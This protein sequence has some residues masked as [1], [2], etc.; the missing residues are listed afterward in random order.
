MSLYLTEHSQKYYIRYS[1]LVAT[2]IHLFFDVKLWY[3]SPNY[4]LFTEF[5]KIKKQ[6]SSNQ[7]DRI[8]IHVN[9]YIKTC[10][11]K[12]DQVY[13]ECFLNKKPVLREI[14]IEEIWNE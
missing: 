14:V 7:R 8:N 12:P 3:Y 5:K 9:K 2:K 6:S 10:N 4:S 11:A 1:Q 13:I